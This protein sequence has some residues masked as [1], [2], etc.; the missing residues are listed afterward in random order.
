MFYN[1]HLL[2]DVLIIMIENEIRPNR[3]IKHDDCVLLYKDEKLVGINILNISQIVKIKTVGKIVLPARPIV[4]IINNKLASLNVEPLPYL[5]HSGFKIGKVLTC[6]EHPDS[7]HLHVLTVD[8]GDDVLNIVCG[9]PNVKQDQKV[10]VA[11][12]YTTMFDGSRIVPSELRGEK[13]VGMLCSPRELHLEGAPQVRGILV[14]DD[15][16][17]VGNDFFQIKGGR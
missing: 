11:M 17:V 15:D 6:E 8:V 16:L 9:A 4:D 3:V 10:V 7:D 12:P 5:D 14:L 2:G 1:Y 13:S